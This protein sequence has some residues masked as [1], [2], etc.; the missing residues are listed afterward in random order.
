VKAVLF[1]PKG[2]NLEIDMSTANHQSEAKPT[3]D[4]EARRIRRLKR[5]AGL[6]EEA[7]FAGY[8]VH[9]PEKEDFLAHH[10]DDGGVVNRAY[11]PTPEYAIRYAD[12][13]RATAVAQSLPRKAVVCAVFDLGRQLAVA[14]DG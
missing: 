5:E 3:S 10:E 8:V 7:T 1:A 12:R 13:A 14:F 9:V 6:P 11:A 2:I 4:E